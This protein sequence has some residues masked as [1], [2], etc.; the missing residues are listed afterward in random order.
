MG[1]SDVINYIRRYKIGFC[2]VNKLCATALD[3]T[4]LEPLAASIPL[5]F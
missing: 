5:W 2:G 1:R 4:E 3:V